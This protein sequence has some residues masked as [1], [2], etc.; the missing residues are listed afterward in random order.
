MASF[1]RSIFFLLAVTAVVT[2]LAS[3]A[4]VAA[5]A[6]MTRLHFYM[7]ATLGGPNVTTVRVVEG[8]A[9]LADS[10]FGDLYVIDDPLT[11]GPA[12][13]SMLVGRAQG[14]YLLDSIEGSGVLVSANLGFAANGPH[15]GSTIAV[16]GSYADD[17]P[18]KELSVVGGSRKFRFAHG[19]VLIKTYS[20]NATTGDSILELDVYVTANK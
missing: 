5:D 1:H 19:Y 18:E 3:T 15:N 13:T 16:Y 10:N 12:P 20:F 6:D 2:A 14:F 11:D 7:H 9:A 4:A 17:Q 8:P